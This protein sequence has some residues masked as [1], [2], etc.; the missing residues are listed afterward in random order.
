MISNDFLCLHPC[1]L[2]V[3]QTSD[4]S[5][6][7]TT[8]DEGLQ[9]LGPLTVIYITQIKIQFKKGNISNVGNVKVFMILFNGYFP[10]FCSVL[11]LRGVQATETTS[12]ATLL[13]AAKTC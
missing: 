8:A 12:F 5:V 7:Q 13:I 6:S 2:R 3:Q 9:L 1:W 11:V 10:L 4:I